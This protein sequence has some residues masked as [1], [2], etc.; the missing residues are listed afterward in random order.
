MAPVVR[1]NLLT[2]TTEER[3]NLVLAFE[4]I[5]A[6]PADD[7]DSFFTIASYH[8]IP[9]GFFCHHGDPLFPTWH[10][11]Y[12]YTL[13]KSLQNQV[14]GVAL[15]YWQ[16]IFAIKEGDPSFV[17]PTILTD[18]TYTYA[19]GQTVPNPLKSYTLQKAIEDTH[20][21]PGKEGFPY[22]KPEGYATV[23][24]PFAGLMTPEYIERT[25]EHNR[26]WSSRPISETTELLNVNVATWLVKSS[27]ITSNGKRLEAGL[28]Y[29]Y[30]RC[31]Y[32][33]SYTAFSNTTSANLWN[34]KNK[35]SFVMSLESPHN[36][37]HLAI[38]GIQVPWQD[39]SA[40]P[41]ANGDMGDNET[42]AFDPIFY[43][44]HAFIDYMFWNWQLKHDSTATLFFDPEYLA[45][46]D[47][48]KNLQTELD[49]FVAPNGRRA[50]TSQ[51]VADIANLGYSYDKPIDLGD[52]VQVTSSD[53]VMPRLVISNI[54][55]SKIQGSFVVTTTVRE[56]GEVKEFIDAEPILS[57]YNVKSC[58]NCLDHLE[59]KYRV[60]LVGW[61]PEE[62]KKVKDKGDF[63]ID[64]HTKDEPRGA[65]PGGHFDTAPRLELE[66]E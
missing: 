26:E 17:I 49:P 34:Q 7:P 56:D 29:K 8:G 30:E 4:R 37:M 38:G 47:K 45:P 51:D 64:I 46:E 50:M 16:E 55:K 18:E 53:T 59:V 21:E 3:D 36:G 54:Y 39:A 12:L 32:A 1:K 23:R 62:A 31:L 44:H 9:G 52:I 48:D 42:A 24:F 22:S 14:P 66:L 10:R 65:P 20:S 43:F 13:E 19:N 6:L 27:Y 2:L 35:D 5:K 40:I 63:F 28:K 11:A 61:S 25:E 33:T 57:R 41:F 58:D 60:A 15:P